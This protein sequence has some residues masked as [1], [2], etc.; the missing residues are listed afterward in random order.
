MASNS[1]PSPGSSGDERRKRA[2]LR[3]SEATSSDSSDAGTF[4][5]FSVRHRV[6]A[7]PPHPLP[8]RGEWDDQCASIRQELGATLEH[9]V[10]ILLSDS[11]ENLK[12]PEVLE[13]ELV[14]RIP[15]IGTELPTKGQPTILIVARWTDES[16]SAT[17]ERAVSK[18]KKFVDSKRVTNGNLDHLDIAVEMI[19]EEHYQEK[20]ISP[21]SAE[22]LAR[23]M[24]TDWARIKDRVADIMASYPHT[25]GHATSIQ[26]FRLGISSNDD[27]NPNTVYVSVDYECLETKWPPVVGEIQQFLRQFTYADLKLYF[28]H[29]IVEQCAFPLVRSRR[30]RAEIEAKQKAFRLLPDFPYQTRVNLG[31]DIS[32]SN[33]LKGSDGN[34]F[35]PL[36]G[37]LGCW[38]EIKTK[39]YPNGVKVALTNYHVIRQAYDGFQLL[40]DSKGESRIGEPKEDSQLWKLDE[41]GIFTESTAPEIEHPTRLKHNFGV[42]ERETIIETIPGQPR[43]QAQK[44]LDDIVAFFDNG[45]HIFGRVFCASGYTRRTDHHGRMDW[46]LVMPLD[47]AR[48]GDNRLP[49]FKTWTEKYFASS[50]HLPEPVTFGSP[51]QQPTKAGLRG[52]C[53]KELVYKVGATTTTTVGKFNQMKADVSIAEDRHVSPGLSEEFSYV[54]TGDTGAFGTKGD[55]GSVVWD[56]KGQAVGLLFTGQKPQG[57]KQTLTYVMAIEDLFMD[58]IK[59]S[60]GEIKEIRIADPTPGN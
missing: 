6:A 20:Y 45:H 50:G 5:I 34:D 58:I 47:E 60:K 8:M 9:E 27:D 22:L 55:S 21:V 16:C 56:R 36:L 28:E 33:Y 46:A 40:V 19:A 13:V 2:R 41:N 53:Q 25:A 18:I 52:V 31:V 30:S 38:L 59:F 26:L 54:N 39:K 7:P 14:S 11:D 48:I 15:Y 35:S 17:W 23:G 43:E 57:A 51:L 44:E 3:R 4:T 24:E 1:Y 29:N 42:Y 12:E 32:A 37:T 10:R 49:T